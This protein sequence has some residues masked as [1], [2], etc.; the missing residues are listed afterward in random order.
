MSICNDIYTPRESSISQLKE[1]ISP[2]QWRENW[3]FIE[4]IKLDVSNHPIQKHPILEQLESGSMT[5]SAIKK[6]HLEYRH[7]IVQIFT[8]ALVMAIFQARQL[9]P[10][11]AA[12]SK[13]TSRF[14][15]TLNTLDEFGFRPEVSPK[16]YYVGS[17][18]AAHYPMFEGV[19]N[20]LGVNTMERNEFNPSDIASEVRCFLE[21][22]Y[23]NYS[24]ILL[25]LAI[26]EEQVMIF[27]P[28]LRCSVAALDID[29]NSGYYHVHGHSDDEETNAYDDDHED[30]LWATLCQACELKDFDQL[31]LRAL[32]YMD[33]WSKFW[34]HQQATHE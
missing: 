5:F 22:S 32:T 10:R 6:I 24:D 20:S 30:D 1:S 26:A 16:G 11:L 3:A 7:A 4:S 13:M 33:L 8:D 9:E 14:I 34:T 31:K 29:V 28:A 12:G 15:L 25:L 27:S 21:G 18:E 2:H 17:S 23:D 19:L